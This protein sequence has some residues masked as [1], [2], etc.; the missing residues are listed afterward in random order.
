[1]QGRIYL[2]VGPWAEVS[3]GALSTKNK[4]FQQ[5]ICR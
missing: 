2:V 3:F 5:S 1:M 4:I